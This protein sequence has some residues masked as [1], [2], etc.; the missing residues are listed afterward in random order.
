MVASGECDG[1]KVS[2]PDKLVLFRPAHTVLPCKV[3]EIEP[4]QTLGMFF[5]YY[6]HVGQ[7]CQG[8]IVVVRCPVSLVRACIIKQA[9]R[10]PA[11]GPTEPKTSDVRPRHVF[12]FP[13]LRRR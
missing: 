3:A 2:I 7:R 12:P 6:M 1:P 4:R 9:E 13:P 11:Y 5:D 8:S 10:I